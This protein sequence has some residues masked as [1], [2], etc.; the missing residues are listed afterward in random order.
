V[1]I[2]F[3]KNEV[4]L[5]TLNVN[6]DRGMIKN[7]NVHLLKTHS[8]TCECCQ[9]DEIKH[10]RRTLDE[11]KDDEKAYQQC[12]NELANREIESDTLSLD[13]LSLDKEMNS[14]ENRLSSL[15]YIENQLLSVLD[16]LNSNPL[17]NV[18]N[19]TYD[20]KHFAQYYS[21]MKLDTMYAM[22]NKTVNQKNTIDEL[23]TR[24]VLSDMFPIWI[25]KEFASIQ[26]LKIHLLVDNCIKFYQ[27]NWD[28]LNAGLGSIILFLYIFCHKWKLKLKYNPY[29]LG[30][31]SCIENTESKQLYPVYFDE[32]GRVATTVGQFSSGM[33]ALLA[34][35]QEMQ[36]KVQVAITKHKLN[37]PLYTINAKQ[38]YIE[39]R[40]TRRR[41]SLLFTESMLKVSEKSKSERKIWNMG[42][43]YVLATLKWFII[44]DTQY[45]R[46]KTK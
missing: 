4:P 33:K 7:Y 9:S 11:L 35:L 29:P 1:N 36:Q 45:T 44:F 38:G 15:T 22:L 3:P 24:N 16:S 41:F 20:I 27:E 12:L 6:K 42:I 28:I 23:K 39:N 26:H 37:I 40:K 14:L 10:L 8:V 30:N 19:Q 2:F 34:S 25:E 21:G 17:S 13:T 18:M 32:S 43:R 46:V 31:L 5:L